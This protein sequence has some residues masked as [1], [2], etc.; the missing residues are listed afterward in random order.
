MNNSSSINEI[1]EAK[2]LNS[3]HK[4]FMV[5]F[6]NETTSDNTSL[7]ILEKRFLSIIKDDLEFEPFKEMGWISRFYFAFDLADHSDLR[8]I[9]KIGFKCFMREVR[10][11]KML[12][13]KNFHLS[14]IDQANPV[15]QE[16]KSDSLMYDRYILM[17]MNYVLDIKEALSLLN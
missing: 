12:N 14:I 15:V 16:T 11:I 4:E 9:C 13:I 1:S 17:E 6:D 10:K 2:I 5:W 7:K 8:E 3:S